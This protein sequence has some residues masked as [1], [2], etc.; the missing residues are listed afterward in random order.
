MAFRVKVFFMISI[1][2]VSHIFAEIN[3]NEFAQRRDKL[4]Q[5]V[6]QGVILMRGAVEYARNGDV[7][8]KFRQNS[9]FYY[10]SGF[11]EPDATM[12]LLPGEAQKFIMFVKPF[13][14]HMAVWVGESYGVEGAMK[15]FKADTAFAND[16]FDDVIKS[17]LRNKET[18]Y[19]PF[20][21]Q[22]FASHI[23]SLLNTHYGRYPK[24][25]EDIDQY[26]NDLRQ[27][28]STKEI[29]LMQKAIDITVD[30]H[31]E[32]MKAI[33]PDMHEYEIAALIKYIYLKNGSER[34][35]FP[36]IVGSGPNSTILH[37]EK[38]ER[39]M[40]QNDMVV[41]DIG[42]EY[43][44]Y[45]ADVTRTV[46]VDGN[47]SEEQ[48]DIYKIVLESQ[49]AG[50]EMTKPGITLSDISN[51]STEIIKNGL[52]DLGLIT[53]KES[54]WQTSVWFMHGV[55]HGLGLETHDPGGYRNQKLEAG[56]VFT[57]EPGIYIGEN[58]LENVYMMS[59]M[60]VSKDAIDAF[61]EAVK[62]AFE[63]YKNIGVR[64]ED[65]VLV[66][67]TGYRNLSEKA[68]REISDIE[69]LMSKGSKFTE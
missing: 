26:I 16:T 40:T 1:F 7:N 4:M 55:S 22:E 32:A 25:I 39:K 46:P 5:K 61:V 45:S 59:R 68:P 15:I 51:K 38:N 31:K 30:A 57:V 33:K 21:D 66:T 2:F 65:D 20:S 27:I 50:V 67:E 24:K 10:L 54:R 37:Y 14:A 6:S 23:T 41:I 8:F 44:M 3:T 56:M 28:K 64:I 35:G 52:F 13:N 9:N 47:F 49:K 58:A 19:L 69:K 53:D 60:G 34:S 63:K 48:K 43:G 11:D 17:Y 12:L 18:V 36:S 62:P 42:A 29:E